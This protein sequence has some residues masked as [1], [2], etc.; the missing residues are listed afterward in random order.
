[1]LVWEWENEKVSEGGE[2]GEGAEGWG[3]KNRRK[4]R[5]KEEEIDELILKWNLLFLNIGHRESQCCTVKRVFSGF[6]ELY[7][8]VLLN[9]S[10]Q[11]SSCA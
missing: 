10:L 6:S 4:E 5:E 8:L 1:M 11:S 7:P 9:K 3:V 2:K